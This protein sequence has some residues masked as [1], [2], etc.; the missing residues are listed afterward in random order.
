MS[1]QSIQLRK[2]LCLF[3]ASRAQ[4]TRILRQDIRALINKDSGG[5]GDGGDF[6]VPFWS[7][8]KRHALDKADL[9]DETALRVAKHGGRERLYPQLRDGFLKWWTEKRRW[10]NDDFQPIEEPA[11]GQY[12]VGDIGTVRVEG[13]LAIQIGDGSH[14]I[15]Y[16]YFSEEPALSEE[17]ARLG[18]WLISKAL[19]GF[20]ID[21]LRILDVLRSRSVGVADLP[22]KGD[23]ARRFEE[24]YQSIILE[25]TTLMGEY[26]RA[27]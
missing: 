5:A 24:K 22:L 27:A 15:I 18:L 13:P 21:D 17:D 16:P 7:D 20:S 8:A 12:V 6:H 25:Y 26:K 14:R 9:H 11:H 19:P 10:R 4:R 1:I 2:L 23:E 3:G